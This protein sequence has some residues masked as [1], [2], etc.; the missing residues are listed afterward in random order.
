VKKSGAS[1]AGHSVEEKAKDEKKDNSFKPGQCLSVEKLG[2]TLGQGTSGSQ[3]SR[4]L[5]DMPDAQTKN[6]TA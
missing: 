6:Q 2:Q 4:R 3:G 5:D 1:A